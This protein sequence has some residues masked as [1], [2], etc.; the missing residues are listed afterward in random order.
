MPGSLPPFDRAV[1]LAYAMRTLRSRWLAVRCHCGASSTPPIKLMLAERPTL[2]RATL[3]D[4]LVSLR[5]H[6]CRARPKSVALVE[7]SYRGLDEGGGGPAERGWR[8][9]LAEQ[10]ERGCG[11]VALIPGVGGRSKVSA[12]VAV[13]VSGGRLV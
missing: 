4:V 1:S 6:V 11:D 9:V 5:C 13:G 2:T 7:T 12:S 10:L 8:L 3:A